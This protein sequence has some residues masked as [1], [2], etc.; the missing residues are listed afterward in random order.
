MIE[1]TFNAAVCGG[2]GS[3][4]TYGTGAY[5][6][7]FHDI[8][9]YNEDGSIMSLSESIEAKKAAYA[10][11]ARRW[12]EATPL[13]GSR[14]DVFDL[15]LDMHICGIS[16]LNDLEARM[17]SFRKLIADH[18][19]G[20]V[21]ALQRSSHEYGLKDLEACIRRAK[22]G[23]HIR[24]WYAD[25]ADERC[26]MMWLVWSLRQAGVPA[27]QVLRVC[28]P[29][30]EGVRPG[31]YHKLAGGQQALSPA[32]MDGI[33]GTWAKL[34][35]ENAPLRAL[36][37]GEIVSVADDFYDE[38]IL[39]QARAMGQ[40][41]QQNWLIGELA[42]RYPGMDED[43]LVTRMEVLFA[44]GRLAALEDSGGFPRSFRK[45]RVAE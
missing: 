12:E 29:S 36:V 26:N 14:E 37:E 45:I 17:A 35:E 23:E 31:D 21:E 27:E 2:V 18:P 9:Y 3:A 43:W 16:G 30:W 33:A 41:L 6:G 4:Q 44:D 28:V 20:D 22:T 10:R 13:G 32:E 15:G 25:A 34:M 5:P 7:G 39:A 24:I 42:R 11:E 1:I 38:V 40:P 19:Q 8:S